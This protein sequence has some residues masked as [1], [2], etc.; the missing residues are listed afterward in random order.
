MV[1]Y[2]WYIALGSILYVASCSIAKMKDDK[3]NSMRKLKKDM[4]KNKDGNTSSDKITLALSL[5]THLLLIR[6]KKSRT[7]PSPKKSS[8][9]RSSSSSPSKSSPRRNPC[10][11]SSPNKSSPLRNPSNSNTSEDSPARN[12]RHQKRLSSPSIQS[13]SKTSSVLSPNKSSPPQTIGSNLSASEDSPARNTR[14]QTRISSPSI[15]SPSK[16][17]LLQSPTL[18]LLSTSLPSSPRE[19]QSII[20]D[21]PLKKG[22]KNNRRE[23]ADAEMLNDLIFELQGEATTNLENPTEIPTKEAGKKDERRLTADFADLRTLDEHLKDVDADL[24]TPQTGHKHSKKS[25][26]KRLPTPFS[27]SSNDSSMPNESN[28]DV[29]IEVTEEKGAPRVLKSILNSNPNHN[30]S[31]R[32][33]TIAFGSPEVVEFNTNSPSGNF[34]PLPARQAR[35]LFKIPSLQSS[36]DES[37]C[38]GS[39]TSPI[40]KVDD[41]TTIEVEGDVNSLLNNPNFDY[42]NNSHTNESNPID[43]ESKVEEVMQKMLT[44]TVLWKLSK[45]SCFLQN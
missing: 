14:S 33:K 25:C 40:N 37:N 34:T 32:K 2:H 28:C 30:M 7:G 1:S 10:R 18:S 31:N 45:E 5:T 36:S 22:K 38:F 17:W 39:T 27:K 43:L 13:P 16:T 35:A 21:S 11:S 29:S 6:S 41:T 4:S 23:T 3:N 12:T 9:L 42:G 24:D 15:Q 8:P 19:D 20:S 26:S 44:L